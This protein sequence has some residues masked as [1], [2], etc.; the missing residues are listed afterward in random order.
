M[1]RTSS[2]DGKRALVT[3]GSRGIGAAIV[4]QLLDAGAEVLTVSDQASWIT[5]REFVVDGGEFPRL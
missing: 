2:L 4:R 5:G 1:T 3:G